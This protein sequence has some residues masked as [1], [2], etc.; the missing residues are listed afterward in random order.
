MGLSKTKKILNDIAAVQ[1]IMPLPLRNFFFEIGFQPGLI[2][3][4]GK[5]FFYFLCILEKE[6]KSR[7]ST[8]K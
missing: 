7:K 8:R 3:T 4:S 1:T 2:L 5:R 6:K